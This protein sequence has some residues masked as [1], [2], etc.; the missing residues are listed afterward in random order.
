[1]WTAP[2]KKGLYPVW[3]RDSASGET[4][5]LNAFVLVPFPQKSWYQPFE[6]GLGLYKANAAPG[7]FVHVDVRGYPARWGP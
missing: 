4:V 5:T 3:V 1:M 7:P 6:G 2:D